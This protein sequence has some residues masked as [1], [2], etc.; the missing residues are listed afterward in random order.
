[1]TI[2]IGREKEKKRITMKRS[3]PNWKG[4]GEHRKGSQQASPAF[5]ASVFF[6]INNIIYSFLKNIVFFKIL[7]ILEFLLLY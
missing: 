6:I 7:F 4:L 1:M 5:F 3:D 2:Q